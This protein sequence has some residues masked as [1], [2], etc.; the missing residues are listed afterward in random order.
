MRDF[1]KDVYKRHQ[2]LHT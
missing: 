2:Y 1:D